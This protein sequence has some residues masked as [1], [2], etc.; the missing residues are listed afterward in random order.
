MKQL[1][2]DIGNTNIHFCLVDNNNFINQ[3]SFST[4][5]NDLFDEYLI[6]INKKID[7]KELDY[8]IL[9]SVV[10][11]L[12]SEFLKF[13]DSLNI[14]LINVEKGIKTGIFLKTDNPNEVGADIICCSAGLTSLEKTI[15][16]DLGTANKY[17]YVENNTL[18]GALFTPGLRTSFNSLINNTALLTDIVFTKPKSV[19]G[20][21]TIDCLNNGI[22]YSV[23]SEIEGIIKRI[24]DNIGKCSVILT[25]GNY[26]YLYDLLNIKYT[27]NKDLI[28]NGLLEIYKKNKE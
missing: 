3:F 8:V 9:S 14:K 7:I 26:Q 12:T 21:N 10:P 5:P 13:R 18:K 23:V 22:I 11:K 20:K 2:I 28:F 25:G 16:V 1:L 24:E 17:I 4:K 27:Y 15:V 19:L 6:L